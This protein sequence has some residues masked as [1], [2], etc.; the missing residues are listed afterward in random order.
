MVTYTVSPEKQEQ[1]NKKGK[2][3]WQMTSGEVPLDD[4]TDKVAHVEKLV[5][6]GKVAP[7]QKALLTLL[8]EDEMIKAELDAPRGNETK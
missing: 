5:A 2:V 8:T 7:K 4:P 6:D 1:R 3:R